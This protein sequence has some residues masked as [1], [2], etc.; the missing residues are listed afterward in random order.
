MVMPFVTGRARPGEILVATS[1]EWSGT[2]P[3]S[4][5]Y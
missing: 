5:T 4:M 2:G 3:M 1:G